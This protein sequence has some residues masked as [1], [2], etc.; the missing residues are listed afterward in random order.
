[1]RRKFNSYVLTFRSLKRPEREWLRLASQ[2]FNYLMIQK[3]FGLVL[4]LC[5]KEFLDYIKNIG[6][7][8]ILKLLNLQKDIILKIIKTKF[9]RFLLSQD[10]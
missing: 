8:E 5:Q 6:L 9:V 4:L 10:L 7:K 2:E 1:M 3:V